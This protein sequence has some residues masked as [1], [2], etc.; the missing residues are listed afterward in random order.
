MIETKHGETYLEGDI[1][2]LMADYTTITK[3]LVM[4]FADSGM[5]EDEAWEKVKRAA[6]TAK[7]SEE[8]L[9]RK[10]FEK[11]MQMLFGFTGE[12]EPVK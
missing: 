7:L 9:K 8:E 2:G 4:A 12:D 10:N 3:A 5:N 11:I 6:D 1:Y